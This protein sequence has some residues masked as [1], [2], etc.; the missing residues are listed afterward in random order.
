MGYI[1]CVE[2]YDKSTTAVVV[3]NKGREERGE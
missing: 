2:Q 1:I 3:E